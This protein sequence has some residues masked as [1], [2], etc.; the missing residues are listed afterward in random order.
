[1]P[2]MCAMILRLDPRRAVVW[3]T[4]DSMQIGVDPA[5]VV[6]DAVSDGD[7]RLVAAL[8]TGVTRAG[9]EVL[10][11]AARV[12][13]DEVE[14]LLAR[15]GPAL[16]RAPAEAEPPARVAV[17]GAGSAAARVARVLAEAGHPVV[18]AAAGDPLDADA[19]VGAAVLVSTHVIDPHEH[20]RWLRR[21]LRH[22]PVVIG[23]D[24]A[25]VGPLVVP[26]STACL[27]CV[28]QRRTAA[29]AAWP[30]IASQLWGS[31]A[32]ADS[33]LLAAEA[34]AAAVR[35]LAGA[36]GR[37]LRIAA[38]DGARVEREWQPSP[39]CGCHGL[40]RAGLDPSGLE[41]SAPQHREPSAAQ[42]GSGRAA[43]RADD[44]SRAAPIAG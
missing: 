2:I 36:G 25:T 14:R 15:L 8:G 17:V 23:E 41:P 1:M 30:A 38:D 29:D 16:T 27:A 22:L 13:D 12:G 39:R 11:H 26:G 20:L 43:P 31:P 6:L 35:M 18:V 10:A 42:P 19:G 9:L 34:G 32:A 37:S 40:E 4:P 21:D 7:A 44:L 5:L 3:R 33:P 28:E 24:S